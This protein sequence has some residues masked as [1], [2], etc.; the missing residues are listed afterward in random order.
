[1]PYDLEL[2]EIEIDDQQSWAVT[3]ASNHI[4][5]GAHHH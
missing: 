2:R 1:M 4:T 5:P 3:Q